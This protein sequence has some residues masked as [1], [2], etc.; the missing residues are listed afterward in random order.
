MSEVT[1]AAAL[2]A[3]RAELV[4]LGFSGDLIER[5]VIAACDAEVRSTGGLTIGELNQPT[6]DA[7]GQQPEPE[8][9]DEREVTD[10]G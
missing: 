1:T 4:T 5:L 2:A 8:Q 7:T 9:E 6:Q 10:H 3:F